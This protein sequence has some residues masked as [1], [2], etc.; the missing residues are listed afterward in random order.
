MSSGS[1]VRIT[2]YPA[3]IFAL[4]YEKVSNL[5]FPFSCPLSLFLQGFLLQG[6]LQK[7]SPKGLRLYQ[8]RVFLLDVRDGLWYATT[9]IWH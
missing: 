5:A 2:G 1:E 9:V 6:L 7:R 8:E 4:I 3:K